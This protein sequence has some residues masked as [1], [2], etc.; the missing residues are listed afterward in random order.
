MGMRRWLRASACATLALVALSQSAQAR[1]R[2]AS[3]RVLRLVPARPPAKQSVASIDFTELYRFGPKAPEFTPKLLALEGKRVTLLG[4]MVLMESPVRG[5]FYLAPYPAASD[6]S[7][8]GRGGVPPTAV[9]VLPKQ[10][11]GKE[12]AY[13]PGALQVTGVLELGNREVNGEITS[14]R[15]RLE[16]PSDLRFARRR[17]TLKAPRAK[18]HRGRVQP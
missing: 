14:I 1:P 7:G 3:A 4:F 12:V 11:E 16:R 17:S 5:G 15:L 8:A 18:A 13:V 9:L 10:A 6:E 2:A